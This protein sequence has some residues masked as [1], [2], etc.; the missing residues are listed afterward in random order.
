MAADVT[1]PLLVLDGGTGH[2]LKERG[3][4]TSVVGDP[5]WRN[6]FLVPALANAEA[7]EAVRQVS[8]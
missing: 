1:H 4:K 5:Q 7:P 3:V 6:S 2:L 8:V